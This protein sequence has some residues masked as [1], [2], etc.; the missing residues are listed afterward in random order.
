M[1]WVRVCMYGYTCGVCA[2]TCVWRPK[3]SFLMT[4][5]YISRQSLSLNQQHD[6]S[7]GLASQFAPG[8]TSKDYQWLPYL[9]SF[10]RSSW[11]LEDQPHTCAARTLPSGLFSMPPEESWTIIPGGSQSSYA[12]R[13]RT[14]AWNSVATLHLLPWNFIYLEFEDETF[15]TFVPS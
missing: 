15:W 8:I 2:G 4:L 12:Q 5:P 11:A 1:V 13:S 9:P 3:A 14:N 10:Y 6:I 7:A